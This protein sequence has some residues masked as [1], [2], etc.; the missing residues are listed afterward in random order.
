MCTLHPE[1]PLVALLRLVHSGSRLSLLFLV[2]LG[3]AMVVASTMQ[4]RLRR[5]IVAK[6]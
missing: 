5:S 2:E 3:A 6:H 4:P 1:V